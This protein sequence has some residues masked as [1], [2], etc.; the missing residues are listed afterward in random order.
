MPGGSGGENCWAL[1][2][3]ALKASPDIKTTSIKTLK[4]ACMV[5]LLLSFN[6]L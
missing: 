1:T 2:E 4:S 5:V 6:N 3:A